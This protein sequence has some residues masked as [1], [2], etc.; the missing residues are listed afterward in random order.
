MTVTRESYAQRPP[1]LSGLQRD[2]GFANVSRTP[3]A[4]GLVAVPRPELTRQDLRSM[5]F[6]PGPFRVNPEAFDAAYESWPESTNVERR[7]AR[8]GYAVGGL[9]LPQMS[10]ASREAHFSA[11]NLRAAIPKAPMSIAPRAPR[12]P[13]VHLINSAVPGRTDRIPMQAHT[14]S[15]IL[16]ADAVSGLGQGNTMAGAKMWGA[17]IAHSV[18]P[19]GIANTIKQRALRAPSL[20]MPSPKVKYAEGGDTEYTPIITAGGEIAIDPEIVHAL[21]DGDPEAGKKILATAVMNVRKHTVA[22][23]KKLPKPVA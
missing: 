5:Q 9:G 13:G 19:M 14:G 22:E 11:P 20:R 1:P 2:L 6:V 12:M 21:G 7:Y 3:A 18:G 15:Y 17:M 16:P 23:L 10:A 4:Q 8:G